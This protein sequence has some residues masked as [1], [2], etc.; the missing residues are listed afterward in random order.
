[1]KHKTI[2]R[3][4]VAV[5]LAGALVSVSLAVTSSASPR[6][7]NEPP[8]PDGRAAPLAVMPVFH[9]IAPPV[10]QGTLEGLGR[11]FPGITGT[12]VFT[13]PTHTG[14]LRFTS[15]NTQTG[16][17]V[18]QFVAGGG[19]FATNFTRAFSETPA[20]LDYQ[21]SFVCDFL[22]SKG[23]FPQGVTPPQVQDCAGQLPYTE[24][25]I[26]LSIVTPTGGLVGA[27]GPDLTHAVSEVVQIGVVYHV[28]LAVDVGLIAPDYIPLGGPGGHLS[29]L[30]TGF[31]DNE[32]LDPQWPG[33]NAIASPF[34]ERS[35]TKIGDYPAISQKEAID[36]LRGSLPAGAIITPGNP[37][38]M[39]YVDHP[40][41]TQTTMMPMWVFTDA[42]ANVGGQEVDLKGLTLP[43]VSG[44]L[45]DVHITAPTD[46]SIYFPGQPLI[47]TGI[48]SGSAAPFTYTL[49]VEGGDVIASGVA[50]GGALQLPLAS[51]PFPLDKGSG[52]NIVL[53]LSVTDG[54]GAIGNDTALLNAPLRV[55]LP[56]VLRDSVG[57]GA[58]AVSRSGDRLDPAGPAALF[59]VGVEW[60]QY[61]NG[62]APDLAGVPPDA[63]GFYNSLRAQ[64][65]TGRFNWGN[66][67]AWEKDW[68]DCALGGIDCTWGVDR[69][70]FV[71]FSGHGSPARIYFGVNKDSY[72]FFGGN[73]RFQNVRWAAFSSCQT[74]RAGP[75]VGTGNPPLT[76]WFNAFQ[77]AYMLLGFHSNMGD[78]AFG[79]PLVDNMRL[80]KFL[81]LPLYGAQRSIREAW[82]L[83][84]FQMN[85]GK[86]AYLYARGNFDPVDFKLPDPMW[87]NYSTP[88]LTGIYQYRWVWWD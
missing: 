12:Q 25:P 67:A 78:I 14:S 27:N 77:G 57:A 43:G 9:L 87:L 60:I 3:M 10:N 31:G 61:Y 68:R 37:G 74:L 7:L 5:M 66:N 33:V 72:D 63:N 32:S 23:L 76:Y 17:S 82:V 46:G 53:I 71:Y 62:T 40:A 83:T 52:D 55:Y 70:E 80:P 41:V 21:P 38:L 8:A 24:T 50:P 44:F 39:Y 30:L 79:G 81:G 26:Y 47:V 75:Y 2:L 16:R 18:E 73:A 11:L 15:V 13:D 69:A 19:F 88:P 54:N 34:H 51:V 56:L 4:L 49:A 20:L 58:R 42:L 29:M 36:Q 65:W 22:K 6:L 1:M 85:A 64:G 28:P 45:P 48:I 35:L 84:A 59:T 86:P